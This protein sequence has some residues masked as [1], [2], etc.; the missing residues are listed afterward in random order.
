[1]A[2]V[3]QHPA[4]KARGEALLR[5]VVMVADRSRLSSA[6]AGVAVF[7][8][9]AV[10]LVG[11]G[12]ADAALGLCGLLLLLIVHRALWVRLVPPL[13]VDS[14][15]APPLLFGASS[16]LTAPRS[17]A[18]ACGLAA[19]SL[20]IV[21]LAPSSLTYTAASVAA[22]LAT[23]AVTAAVVAAN[24]SGG[25]GGS[26]VAG[27][28]PSN[29]LPPWFVRGLGAVVVTAATL[30]AS[31]GYHG[32]LR[33]SC[34]EPAAFADATMA[35]TEAGA[36]SSA[37]A[38]AAAAAAPLCAAAP[39]AALVAAWASLAGLAV[40]IEHA[41]AHDS[42]LAPFLPSRSD[43][44]PLASQP[45]W[46]RLRPAVPMALRRAVHVCARL[47]L[48]LLVGAWLAPSAVTAVATFALTVGGGCPPCAAEA[49]VEGGAA[50]A[51]A[52][53]VAPPLLPA[54][55]Y[56]GL[57][58]WLALLVRGVGFVASCK[59]SAAAVHVACAH[60][61]M[62]AQ[63]PPD[64]LLIASYL[65]STLS[66]PTDCRPIASCPTC[67]VHDAPRLPLRLGLPPRR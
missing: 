31:L 48:L 62:A 24:G 32:V 33:G 57:L 5:S 30:L 28:K 14:K 58:E 3:A 21:S 36:A 50:A 47:T 39:H 45:A 26:A 59:L 4:A 66:R 65:P 56:E 10:P 60:R 44:W 18:A 51:A 67:Q 22:T 2:I 40:G 55:S 61:P 15:D 34:A 29:A 9:V 46:M 64:G 53:E 12:L 13:A 52:A 41:T 43:A 7:H 63:W 42:G 16:P 8:V 20:S 49:A 35:A 54:L 19:A 17:L 38:A 6:A 25:A 37:A 27:A 23:S 1:M 11:L